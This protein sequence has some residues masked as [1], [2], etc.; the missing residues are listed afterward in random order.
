MKVG[1]TGEQ[2]TFLPVRRLSMRMK[3]LILSLAVAASA[4]APARAQLF[5][6]EIARN[7][8]A[9]SVVGAIV[10][11]NSHHQ[12]LAGA[13]IGAI[14]G[15]LWSAATVP[16][17]RPAYAQPVIT[18]APLAPAACLAYQPAPVVIV[19]SAPVVCAP[20]PVVYVSPP[21]VCYNPRGYWGWGY[22]HRWGRR[23]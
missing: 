23:W 10:G 16:D 5:Q 13:V 19:Q 15:G 9:G 7:I 17:S 8:L 6:P 4:V 2:E 21:A 18:E 12:A 3:T 11:D 20:A 1:M 22:P 14:A